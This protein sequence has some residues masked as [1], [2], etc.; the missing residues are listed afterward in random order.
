MSIIIQELA[1]TPGGRGGARNYNFATQT[2]C[3]LGFWFLNIRLYQNCRLSSVSQAEPTKAVIKGQT[4]IDLFWGASKLIPNPT[5]WNFLLWDV[6]H[7]FSRLRVYLFDSALI[8]Q[9]HCQ[10]NSDHNQRLADETQFSTW[11]YSAQIRRHI[12]TRTRSVL[13]E[14][15]L[16]CRRLPSVTAKVIFRSSLKRYAFERREAM[17]FVTKIIVVLTFICLCELSDA[18]RG[19][20]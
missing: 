5:R 17:N 15:Q 2:S 14:S 19:K 1:F 8:S 12:L 18:R 6:S 11:L 13:A 16:Y 4:G 3:C 10:G 20:L 9:T 7:G